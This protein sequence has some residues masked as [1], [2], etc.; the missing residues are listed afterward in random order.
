MALDVT[1]W[2]VYRDVVLPFLKESQLVINFDCPAPARHTVP[3]NAAFEPDPVRPAR[4]TSSLTPNCSCHIALRHSGV[5]DRS[6]LELGTGTIL[7]SSVWGVDANTTVRASALKKSDA[8]LAPFMRTN[9]R[10]QLTPT[11]PAVFLRRV[12]DRR[13]HVTIPVR[14]RDLNKRLKSVLSSLAWICRSQ[15]GS[16]FQQPNVSTL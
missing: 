14:Q 13:Q 3:C 16:T 5:S 11:W 7:G 2:K 1:E 9:R 12:P 4:A 15:F 10:R 6:E 8:T